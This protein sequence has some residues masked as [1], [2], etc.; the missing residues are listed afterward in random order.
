MVGQVT[1]PPN[2]K[3]LRDV[4]RELMKW[5]EKA[6]AF[7]QGVRRDIQRHGEGRDRRLNHA[8]GCSGAR[9]PVDR[10]QAGLR[11]GDGQDTVRHVQ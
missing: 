7:D 10:G 6:K 5:E 1:N 9:V 3:E 11:R 2:V 4:E 8:P